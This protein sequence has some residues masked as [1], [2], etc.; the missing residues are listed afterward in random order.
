VKRVKVIQIFSIVIVCSVLILASGGYVRSKISVPSPTPP[1]TPTPQALLDSDG[2]GMSDWFETNIAHYNPSIPND[3]YI[4]I[5]DWID[6]DPYGFVE[7]IKKQYDFFVQAE[8]IPPENIIQLTNGE[9]ATAVNFKNAVE[10]VAAKADENDLV[11]IQISTHGYTLASFTADKDHP[12]GNLLESYQMLSQWINKINAKAVI[13]TVIS[14]G[15]EQ[16]DYPLFNGSYPRI[17][18]TSSAGEFIGALGEYPEYA[19]IVDTKYG[20]GDGYIS[21]GEIGN[22]IDNDPKWGPDWGELHEKGRSFVEAEGYSK[23][24]DT[25]SIASKIYLTDYKNPKLAN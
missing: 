3:R 15:S 6:T 7:P 22:W 5:F 14:C 8:K 2:D 19:E 10:Q 9:T 20:N 11:F 24:S 23:M 18:Y 21:V 17:V 12:S 4:I 25:S 13:I 16:F 1:P